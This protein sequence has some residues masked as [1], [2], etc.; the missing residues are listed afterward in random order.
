MTL[1]PTTIEGDEVAC[2]VD[3]INKPTVLTSPI[4][5]ENSPLLSILSPFPPSPPYPGYSDPTRRET[6]ETGETRGTRE[7]REVSYDTMKQS[8]MN[9]SPRKRSGKQIYLSCLNFH[10]FTNCLLVS[11]YPRRNGKDKR[12][13][14]PPH[15]RPIEG[16]KRPGDNIQHCGDRVGAVKKNI[17]YERR[18]HLD[19][20]FEKIQEQ[21]VKHFLEEVSFSGNSW[22]DVG[23]DCLRY[24]EKF[25]SNLL[26]EKPNE[27]QE[28]RV[29]L[30]FT[31]SLKKFD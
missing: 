16:S 5:S 12:G 9:L 27:E 17:I 20:L 31:V 11:P 3:Y 21:L 15:T 6:R 29:D 8:L 28:V 26:C 7:I 23:M 4:L 30:K 10:E 25:T 24:D 22:V 18:P 13:R 14:V 19:K 2:T 1:S